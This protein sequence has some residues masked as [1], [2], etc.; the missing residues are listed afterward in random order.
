MISSFSKSE[1]KF[2]KFKKIVEESGLFDK[3]FYLKNYHDA[4]VADATPVEHYCRVGIKE[5]RKPNADFDPVWYREFYADVKNSRLSPFEHYIKF[6]RKE[7]RFVNKA[8]N[9]LIKTFNLVP[10]HAIKQD[11]LSRFDELVRENFDEVYYLE[12]NQDIVDSGINPFDHYME[13]GWKEGRSPNSWFSPSFYLHMYLDVKQNGAEPLGHYLQYGRI[14]GRLPKQSLKDS[15]EFDYKELVDFGYSFYGPIFIVFFQFL[16]SY[17]DKNNVNKLYFLAREGYFLKQMYE[18]LVSAH[19]VKKIDIEYLLVSRA[20]LFRILLNRK[21]DFH[22]ALKSDFRG[23]LNSLLQHRFALNVNEVSEFS[24]TQEELNMQIILPQDIEKIKLILIEK[25]QIHPLD[26]IK[27]SYDAYEKYLMEIGFMKE[28]NPCVVDLGY[29][30]TIQKTLSRIFKKDIVGVYFISSNKLDYEIIDDNKCDFVS[31]FKQG[32]TF[33]DGYELL[34]K[35]LIF[36]GLLTSPDGQLLNIMCINN[37]I[38]S[39]HGMDALSQKKFHYLTSIIDGATQFMIEM[40]DAK[41]DSS[42]FVDDI[43]KM[44]SVNVKNIDRNLFRLL[45]MDDF[46]SGFDI[47]NP[48]IM[49]N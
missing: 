45:E 6:G 26:F 37:N 29:A 16:N 5:D 35:S 38:K 33:G 3:V 13:F 12:N 43:E 21:E 48:S 2:K 4:R 11:K 7:N 22:Y 39:L 49:I 19:F 18:K 8:E 41:V 28:E 34:E 40:Y 15:L 27:D 42:C 47:I 31:C 46:V 14:E 10:S 36:E 23:T 44:F 32:V 25:I 30:G 24:L 17:I 9:I 20:F 1:R